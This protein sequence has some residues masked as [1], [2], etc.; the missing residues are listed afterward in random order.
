MLRHRE[1]AWSFLNECS[2][3][4]DVNN[5]NTINKSHH[6]FYG[7]QPWSVYAHISQAFIRKK[8]LSDMWLKWQH[9]PIHFDDFPLEM[10]KENLFIDPFIGPFLI[11]GISQPCW[12]RKKSNRFPHLNI[13]PRRCMDDLWPRTTWHGPCNSSASDL[14][15]PIDEQRLFLHPYQGAYA[16]E[17]P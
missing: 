15:S 10:P 12:I 6:H 8:N 14:G 9:F 4:V 1:A 11:G 2:S 17:G 13:P 3:L 7:A 5:V 16:D